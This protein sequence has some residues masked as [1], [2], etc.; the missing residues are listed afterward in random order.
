[1][2]T[3]IGDDVSCWGAPLFSTVR[4]KSKPSSLGFVSSSSPSERHILMQW[5]FQ[6]NQEVF[7]LFILI[8]VKRDNIKHFHFSL[9]IKLN[10]ETAQCP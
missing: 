7:P 4:Q 3:F 8:A 5:A 9:Q 10:S 1:M 6:P 2:D